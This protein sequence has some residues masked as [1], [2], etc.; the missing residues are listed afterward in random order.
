[1]RKVMVLGGTGLIGSALLQ[2]LSSNPAIQQIIAPTRRAMTVANDK[3]VNRVID[4]SNLSAHQELFN[5]DTLFSCLGTTRREAGSIKA[6]RKVDVDYQWVAAKLANEHGAQSYYLVSSSGANSASAN[7]YLQMK[8]ELEDAVL[9]LPFDSIAI[10]QPSLLL[11][12]RVR[13]RSAERLGAMLLPTLCKLPFLRDFRPIYGHQVALKMA[14]TA[15]QGVQGTHV[16]RLNDV[17]PD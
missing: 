6:Q 7:A 2:Y 13:P 15:Q 3:I 9:A 14:Q 1:M 11:G 12:E 17:F 5:V 8:G 4:F 16:F 10:F